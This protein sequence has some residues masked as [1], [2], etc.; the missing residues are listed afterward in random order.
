MKPTINDNYIA[1]AYRI[2]KEYIEAIKTM[3]SKTGL[4][5]HY[6]SEIKKLSSIFS[7][8]EV[9]E[10]NQDMI[11]SRLNEIEDYMEKTRKQIQ[12][13]YDKIMELKNDSNILYDSIKEKYPTLSA[14]EI[15]EQIV[16]YVSEIK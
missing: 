12:P 7:I 8:E 11:N 1:E 9:T 14:E 13:L 15:K 16:P 4:L 2:R 3:E 6:K 5:E 10:K